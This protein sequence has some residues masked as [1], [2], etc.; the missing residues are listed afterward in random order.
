MKKLIDWVF[1][2]WVYGWASYETGPA[3]RYRSRARRR[4]RG[5]PVYSLGYNSNRWTEMSQ[6]WWDS[7]YPD[8]K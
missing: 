8:A 7:F 1:N 5:G 6:F 2:R 4:A 3:D